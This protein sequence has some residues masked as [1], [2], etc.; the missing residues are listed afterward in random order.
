MGWRSYSEFIEFHDVLRVSRQVPKLK[1]I[2]ELA[3]KFART[4]SLRTPLYNLQSGEYL[5]SDP[6]PPNRPHQEGGSSDTAWLAEDEYVAHFRRNKGLHTVVKHIFSGN[7][8]DGDFD[9]W[10]CVPGSETGWV[11]ISDLLWTVAAAAFLHHVLYSCSS[12]IPAAAAFLHSSPVAVT[13]AAFQEAV[14]LHVQA[15]ETY[16]L[17][18][19]LPPS[20]LAS[21]C[22]CACCGESGTFD[23]SALLVALVQLGQDAA[24]NFC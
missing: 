13:E 10:P 3:A 11:M 20:S 21:L 5:G 6:M 17:L 8:V 23:T 16:S 9:V 19:G 22:N 15:V 2:S 14:H 7:A 18:L 24:K 12:C 1:L 4:S